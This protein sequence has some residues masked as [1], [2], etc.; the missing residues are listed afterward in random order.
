MEEEV[1]ILKLMRLML[2][3]WYLFIIFI[4][5]CGTASLMI[6]IFMITP[7]YKS[8]GAL[9]VTSNANVSSEITQG[10]I[11]ASQKLAQ[12]Y[13]E[14]LMRR[15]FL[16]EVSAETGNRYS[17]AQLQKML[18]VTPIN[19]TE[20]LE[21]SVVSDSPD[22][23]YLITETVLSRAGNVLMDVIKSGS[24]CVVDWANKPQNPISPNPVK[25]TLIGV[26]IG[27]VLAAVVIFMIDLFDTR[28]RS[29]EEAQLIIEQPNLG[30]IPE[31]DD[32]KEA[33]KGRH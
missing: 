22:E 27:I 9:Y 24:V 11:S 2:K 7:K 32:A 10:M 26:L 28:V 16:I 20:L 30:Q 19:G 13:A 18:K 1:D 33:V 25:N 14:I 21:V 29:C 4:L 3:R 12:T 15:N 23:A 31:Y 5:I 8:D 6:T 17:V